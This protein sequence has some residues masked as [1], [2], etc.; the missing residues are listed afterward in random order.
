MV[1]CIAAA[2]MFGWALDWLKH[3]FRESMKL[4]V[5]NLGVMILRPGFP[6]TELR[7]SGRRSV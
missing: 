6:E 3:V 7:D 5:S 1:G 2:E 4:D